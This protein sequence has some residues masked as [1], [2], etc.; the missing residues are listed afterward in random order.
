M[1]L[2]QVADYSNRVA[3]A[4][5]RLGYK[6]GDVVA[7]LMSNCPEYVAVWLGLSKL[8]VIAAL[9][10]HNQRGKALVHSLT[11]AK[12]RAIIFGADLHQGR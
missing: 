2:F 4:F 11:I 7:L 10:N 1:A 6:K 3:N 8:G 9:I 5:S 12:S